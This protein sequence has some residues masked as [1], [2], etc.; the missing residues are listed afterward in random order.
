MLLA[1]GRTFKFRDREAGN[2]SHSRPGSRKWASV[3]LAG[4]QQKAGRL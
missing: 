2:G 3:A 1:K 4:W